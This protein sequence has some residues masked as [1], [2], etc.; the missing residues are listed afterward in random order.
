[1]RQPGGSCKP[2]AAL[3][4]SCWTPI[5]PTASYLERTH[6]P[7]CSST[8]ADKVHVAL[9]YATQHGYMQW[10]N[11]QQSLQCTQY[12]SCPIK[13]TRHACYNGALLF[14]MLEKAGPC[15][16]ATS[17]EASPQRAVVVA[18]GMCPTSCWYACSS[19]LRAPT[20]AGWAPGGCRM[21]RAECGQLPVST[22]NAFCWQHS[23]TR[24]EHTH[25]HTCGHMHQSRMFILHSAYTQRASW[26]AGVAQA[27]HA[28][29]HQVVQPSTYN[30]GRS[31]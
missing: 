14:K 24:S 16:Q 7:L 29:M 19:P 11:Q 20:A 3:Q 6:A 2:A 30:P 15:K 17:H 10:L 4:L 9:M 28:V 21:Q 8:S 27:T 13:R 23:T 12:Q 22:T 25:A 1:M 26:A 31:G 18:G 5:R